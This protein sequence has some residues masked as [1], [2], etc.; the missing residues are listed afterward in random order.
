MSGRQRTQ[1]GCITL[2]PPRMMPDGLEVSLHTCPRALL[3]ELDHVFPAVDL[4]DCLAIPT[5]QK[6]VMD[7]VAMGDTVETEKD[8]LLNSRLPGDGCK[9]GD[10]STE[11]FTKVHAEAPSSPTENRRSLPG[12]ST[13]RKPRGVVAKRSG[14]P[15]LHALAM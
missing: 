13:I 4:D 9:H 14:R 12:E 10:P 2:Q 1:R 8:V 3:R 5:N 11:F 7:L 6:A 15:T